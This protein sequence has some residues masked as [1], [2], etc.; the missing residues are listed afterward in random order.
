[1]WVPLSVTGHRSQPDLIKTGLSLL[2]KLV[3]IILTLHESYDNLTT[4]CIWKHFAKWINTSI[5][6]LYVS[7]ETT[8]FYLKSTVALE[9]VGHFLRQQELR[10]PG[11]SAPKPLPNPG[12]LVSPPGSPVLSPATQRPLYPA[13]HLLLDP[14]GG[15]WSLQSP[16]YWPNQ[17]HWK[18]RHAPL[19]T[20]QTLPGRSRPSW[21]LRVC[22]PP[23]SHSAQPCRPPVTFTARPLSLADPPPGVPAKGTWH[24]CVIYRPYSDSG[25]RG[26]DEP[27][28]TSTPLHLG[29]CVTF[30]FILL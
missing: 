7:N 26:R 8:C 12:A 14:P 27:P 20:R 4:F 10:L 11:S 22:L 13:G 1:M 21:K 28:P 18:P 16:L 6:V 15:V 5:C 29:A 17:R 23:G 24:L 2:S 3:L 30:C 19:H 25:G 9:L